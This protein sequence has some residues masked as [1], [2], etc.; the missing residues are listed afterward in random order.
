MLK[1][2]TKVTVD[3]LNGFN[4]SPIFSNSDYKIWECNHGYILFNKKGEYFVMTKAEYNIFLSQ[5]DHNNILPM[6]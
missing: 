3:Y 4:L 2:D 1:L 5:Y 6:G